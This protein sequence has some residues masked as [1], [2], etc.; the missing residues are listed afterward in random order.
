LQLLLA[1]ALLVLIVAAAN[2]ANLLAARASDRDRELAVR[3]ALGAGR[4]RVIRLLISEALIIGGGSSVLALAVA[5]WLARVVVPLLPGLADPAALDVGISWRVA[6]VVA[7]LGLTTTFLASLVPIL[8]V[9]RRGTAQALAEGGRAA[10]GSG[11]IR[12]ALVVAQFALSLALVVAAALLIRTLINVR[13]IATGLD[14]N[15]VVLMEVDPEAAG[16]D[17]PRTRQYLT[18]ALEGLR[19]IPGVMAAG[20]GRVIP[21]GFGGSRSSIEI[22]GHTPKPDED[23]EINFNTVS[24]GYFEALGIALVSGRLPNDQDSAGRRR[25]AV[26]NE[27]LAKRYWPD[28]AVGRT[29]HFVGNTPPE[30]EVIGVVRDVKYRFIR[31]EATPTFYTAALQSTTMRGGVLHVRTQGTPGPLMAMVRKTLID[32]DRN[33]PV[34]MVRTLREQRDRNTADERLAVT[35]GVVLGGVALALA[36]VGLFAAMSSAVVSRRREIGVRLA[37]GAHPARVVRLVLAGSLRLV[38]IGAALGFIGA[39]W[40]VQFLEQRL[41]GVTAHDPASFVISVLVLGVVALAAAWAPARR[42]AG[43]D[44]IQALR[45]E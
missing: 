34:T 11:R 16:Y 10:S 37:L 25:V 4:S 24:P 36:A 35:I 38:L 30:L 8:S 28:G 2:V 19:Q 26:I 9:G 27:T 45:T 21:L 33:V 29:M 1:A 31:E 18:S 15:R 13:G 39:Y 12:H 43:I 20:Y 40:A 22:P 5:G 23:M 7:L 14:L 6:G 32:V 44:P 42:A 41:Y 3:M 17:G